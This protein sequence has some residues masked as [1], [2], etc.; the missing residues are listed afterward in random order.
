MS[1]RADLAPKLVGE[2]KAY[3]FDFSSQ[4][5]VGVT[6]SSPTVTA[7][8]YSGTDSSPSSI[9]SGSASAAGAVVT[10]KITAGTLG[11]IYELLCQVTTSDGQTLQL[12]GLLAIIADEP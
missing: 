1:T 12:V 11:V 8:V 10:Q 5:G 3:T 6:L 4:L 2:T 7:T 9:V